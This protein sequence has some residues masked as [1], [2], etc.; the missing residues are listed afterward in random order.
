MHEMPGVV[1]TTGLALQGQRRVP[2]SRPTASA[3][4]DGSCI[5]PACLCSAC[6][7]GGSYAAQIWSQ[8]GRQGVIRS[9]LQPEETRGLTRS[10]DLA[11]ML[12]FEAHLLS[13][14]WA[15]RQQAEADKASAADTGKGHLMWQAPS[16]AGGPY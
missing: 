14:G 13:A 3:G 9:E 11:R 16:C 2:D 6:L 1:C 15:N 5:H 12:P 4:T 7:R 8:R 10:G